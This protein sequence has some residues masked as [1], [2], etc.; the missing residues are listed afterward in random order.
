MTL[1][2]RFITGDDLKVDKGYPPEIKGSNGVV[3]ALYEKS[4]HIQ[5]LL[6]NLDKKLD[7]FQILSEGRFS[8][9]EERTSTTK[10]IVYTSLF[11]ALGA[12]ATSVSAVVWHI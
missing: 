11:F 12:I 1:P 6:E 9:L 4:D 8:K 7:K 3:R 10:N 2:K 5:E